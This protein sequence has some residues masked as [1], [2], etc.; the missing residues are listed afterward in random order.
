M[1][2]QGVRFGTSFNNA[3]VFGNMEEGAER[4]DGI[5]TIFDTGSSDI[6]L[7]VLWYESVIDK[8]YTT[9]GLEY[10]IINGKAQ[11]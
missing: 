7:S 2:M 9:V 3:Y 10:T 11:A 5:Y 8:Y 4:N 6:L 1:S